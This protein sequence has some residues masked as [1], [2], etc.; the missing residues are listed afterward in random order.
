[1]RLLNAGNSHIE[2]IQYM[3]DLYTKFGSEACLDPK[4]VYGAGHSMGG[5][6]S[7][8]AACLAGDLFAAVAP[9]AFDLCGDDVAAKCLL[10]QNI[11]VKAYRTTNDI[12]PYGGGTI[13]PPDHPDP[14][15]IIGAEKNFKLNA[16]PQPT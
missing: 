16:T 4:R 12:V 8:Y 13:T 10:H 14:C 3:R 7:Q 15:A 11:G 9:S 5:G 1:M 6:M 2:Y